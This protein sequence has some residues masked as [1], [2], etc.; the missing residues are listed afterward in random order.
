MSSIF[1][2]F[3]DRSEFPEKGDVTKVY[4]VEPSYYYG[5]LPSSKGYYE[6]T[7]KQVFTAAL[8]DRFGQLY[9]CIGTEIPYNMAWSNG[10]GG[11]SNAVLLAPA[12]KPGTMAKS[13]SPGARRMIFVGTYYGVVAIYDRFS[14]ETSSVTKNYLVYDAP[15]ELS[16]IVDLCDPSGALTEELWDDF[17]G[18]SDRVNIG[19]YL[20]QIYDSIRATGRWRG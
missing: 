9:D 10:Q 7:A 15:V 4:Q 17:V 1:L 5:W 13:M 14:H 19:E 18:S 3:K 16:S 6:L 12:I 2:K 11:Q 8:V 20:K